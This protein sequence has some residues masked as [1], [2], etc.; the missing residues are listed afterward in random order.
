M[1]T[2]ALSSHAARGEAGTGFVPG[3]LLAQDTIDM[4]YARF[5]FENRREH[6]KS[7]RGRERAKCLGPANPYYPPML[8]SP[9]TQTPTTNRTRHTKSKRAHLAAQP[10]SRAACMLRG[11]YSYTMLN[12][13]YL[14]ETS[15][16]ESIPGAGRE[17]SRSSRAPPLEAADPHATHVHRRIE[18][19]RELRYKSL[20]ACPAATTQFVPCGPALQQSLTLASRNHPWVNIQVLRLRR[21]AAL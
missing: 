16:D 2:L 14:V 13:Q 15:D 5:I 12:I 10:G 20:P 18:Y 6:A 4:R 19:G 9:H 1:D 11:K 8:R 7:R 21:M 3:C 17:A